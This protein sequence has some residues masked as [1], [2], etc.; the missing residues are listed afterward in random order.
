MQLIHL[1]QQDLFK[2]LQIISNGNIDRITKIQHKKTDP[3]DQEPTRKNLQTDI[4]NITTRQDLQTNLT[5]S[6]I[7]GWQRGRRPEVVGAG[8]LQPAC[9]IPALDTRNKWKQLCALHSCMENLGKF[10]TF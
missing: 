3:T 5:R 1:F 6:S 8:L 2:V 9:N 10:K 4:T 7:G